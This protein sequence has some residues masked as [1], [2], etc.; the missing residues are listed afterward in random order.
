[1]AIWLLVLIQGSPLLIAQKR[2]YYCLYY[3]DDF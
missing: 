3:K 1:M 2:V